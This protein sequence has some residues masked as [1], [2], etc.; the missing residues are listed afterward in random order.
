[1]FTNK[2]PLSKLENIQKRAVRFLLGDYPSGYTDLLQNANVPGIKIMV[3]RYLA[4]EVFKCFKEINPAYLS[5]MLKRKE[6]PCTLRDSSIFVSAKGN[7]TQYG[8]KYFKSYGTR[9]YDAISS[10]W[11]RPYIHKYLCG[12]LMS[13]PY[14]YL[15]C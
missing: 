9:Q 4:I 6:C 3:L 14:I 5:S 13:K 11:F 12:L 10:Y 1:M 2:T 15:L 7:L 8:F